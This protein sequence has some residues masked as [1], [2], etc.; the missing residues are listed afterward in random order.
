MKKHHILVVVA[1]AVFAYAAVSATSALALTSQ[2]LCSGLAI[3]T[4]AQAEECLVKIENAELLLEESKEKVDVICLVD[5]H[6]EP[7]VGGTTLLILEVAFLECLAA[8]IV[9]C[10]VVALNLTWKSVISLSGT[11]YLGSIVSNGS[12]VPTYDAECAGKKASCTA[13]LANGKEDYT[14]TLVQLETDIDI[15]FAAAEKGKCEGGGEGILVGEFLVP[16]T[17]G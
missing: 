6:I 1:F 7:T 13:E 5:V 4:Q 8:G 16:A 15:V 14:T 2:V 12:G 17:A 9:A 3:T 10:T 11:S